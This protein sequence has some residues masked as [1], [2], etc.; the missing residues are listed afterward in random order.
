MQLLKI[1]F[2]LFIS[3]IN[4]NSSEVITSPVVSKSI[5]EQTEKIKIS[6]SDTVF[7]EQNALIVKKNNRIRTYKNLVINAMALTTSLEIIDKNNFFLI[8]E[9]NASTTKVKDIYKYTYK[10]RLFL[11]FKETIKLYQD[12][13]GSKR[14]YFNQLEIDDQEF[15]VLESLGDTIQ[16]SYQKSQL[17]DLIRLYD[18][19]GKRI[20]DIVYRFSGFDR[21]VE[22]PLSYSN[23]S[24][25]YL[26][27][28]DVEKLNNTSYFL[29]QSGDFHEAVFLLEKIIKKYPKRI[30]A[31]LN[32]A[33]TYWGLKNKTKAKNYY[34]QYIE[35]IKE[36]RIENKIPERVLERLKY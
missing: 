31:Y 6:S 34:R 3:C 8:Y 22:S 20:G 17:K 5:S 13:T 11:T 30:V 9:Y 36:S 28:K 2:F 14:L 25:E 7:I 12:E 10:D 29:E 35:L 18:Y 21:F 16:V 4:R 26:D 1:F 23:D 24:I 15:D 32:L 19:K 27:I 33:D